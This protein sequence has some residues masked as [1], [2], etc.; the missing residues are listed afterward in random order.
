MTEE[1]QS[2]PELEAA[3]RMRLLDLE[4]R[5]HENARWW[6][7]LNRW[8]NPVGLVIMV[9]IVSFNLTS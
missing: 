8:M 6:R 3:L 1:D 5:R 7:N 2:E 4:R 9:V